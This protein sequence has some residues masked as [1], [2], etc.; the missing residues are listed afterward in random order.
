MDREKLLG[1]LRDAKR[2]AA[3]FYEYDT[4]GLYDDIVAALFIVEDASDA[5]EEAA[6]PPIETVQSHRRKV[7]F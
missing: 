1:L 7:K 4:E 3:W 5:Y 6:S 2:K